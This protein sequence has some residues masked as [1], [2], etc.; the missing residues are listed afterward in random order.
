MASIRVVLTHEYREDNL[1]FAV[2][3][4]AYGPSMAISL[5]IADSE[6]EK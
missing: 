5:L 3:P 4:P 1:F 2:V 6:P